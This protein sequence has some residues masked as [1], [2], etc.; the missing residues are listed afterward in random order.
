MNIFDRV[1][2]C[3]EHLYTQFKNPEGDQVLCM[4][5]KDTKR[6]VYFDVKLNRVLSKQEAMEFRADVT[7]LHVIYKG[8]S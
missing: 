5:H 6:L 1:E 4:V 2:G 7:G 8:N 3:W